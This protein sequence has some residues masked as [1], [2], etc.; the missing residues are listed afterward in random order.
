MVNAPVLFSGL[1][2]GLFGV[3]QVN[4]RIP[5]E[6]PAG[7]QVPLTVRVNDQGIPSNTVTMAIAQ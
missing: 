2:P 5:E 6:A 7:D 3:Y 4:A 1:T